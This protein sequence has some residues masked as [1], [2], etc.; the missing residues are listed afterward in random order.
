MK[1]FTFKYLDGTNTRTKTVELPKQA[2]DM[3]EEAQRRYESSRSFIDRNLYHVW[4]QSIKSY[5]M[6]T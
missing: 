3:A 4:N 2:A 1:S 6:F 5:M